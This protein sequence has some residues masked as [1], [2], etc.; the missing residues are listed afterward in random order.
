MQERQRSRCRRGC[1]SPHPLRRRPRP[2]T[3]PNRAATPS[4]CPPVPG[5]SFDPQFTLWPLPPNT[6]DNHTEANTAIDRGNNTTGQALLFGFGAGNVVQFA[7]GGNIV[8]P[9]FA[10]GTDNNSNNTTDGN[11]AA[12]VGNGSTS[13][14]TGQTGQGLLIDGNGNIFQVA[15]LQGNIIAPQVA[16]LGNNNGDHTAYGNY[17]GHRR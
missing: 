13:D 6:S 9:Q 10:V 5:P 3:C 14:S 15:F 16:V 8:A 4:R 1:F 12:G 2:S 7:T 17:G 11:Y